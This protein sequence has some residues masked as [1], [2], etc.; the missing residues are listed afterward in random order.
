MVVYE[1]LTGNIVILQIGPLIAPD[2][3]FLKY[4]LNS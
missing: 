2:C 3:T 1:I 4:I